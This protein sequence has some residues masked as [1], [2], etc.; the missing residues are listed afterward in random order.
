MISMKHFGNVSFGKKKS[1]GLVIC[2]DV[3]LKEV[4][5]EGWKSLLF[6]LNCFAKLPREKP[7]PLKLRAVCFTFP[8]NAVRTEAP[9]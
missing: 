7:K 9:P 2:L 4:F 6:L 5:P 3:G 8:G 1:Q